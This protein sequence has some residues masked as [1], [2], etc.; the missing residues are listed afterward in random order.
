MQ[1]QQFVNSDALNDAFAAQLVTILEQAIAERGAAYLVVSGGRTPQVLFAKLA[2]TPLAWEKV[3]VLLADD[4]YLP[5][6]A[7]HS[8]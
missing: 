5:P 1:L 8:N 4:R 7:E 3:T 6:D 2:D